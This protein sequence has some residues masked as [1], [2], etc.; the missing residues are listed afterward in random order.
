MQLVPSFKERLKDEASTTTAKS[1]SET[2]WRVVDRRRKRD[3]HPVSVPGKDPRAAMCDAGVR[4]S[5]D[6][7]GRLLSLV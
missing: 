4:D 3:N 1:T 6:L 2:E 5:S 7:A